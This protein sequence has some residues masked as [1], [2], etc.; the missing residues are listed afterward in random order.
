MLRIQFSIMAV[1]AVLTVA[2]TGA[3]VP[4]T[5]LVK[6]A[7]IPGRV[8]GLPGKLE[9]KLRAPRDHLSSSLEDELSKLERLRGGEGGLKVAFCAWESLHTV[10]VGGIAPHVSELAAGLQRRGNELHVF[11]RAMDEHGGHEIVDGVHLHKC[12]IY[13]DSDL[14]TECNNMCNS[15][16]H[17]VR[18]TEAHMN[19]EFDII[20]CHD[21]LAAKALVQMKQ[22][23]RRCILT[24]HST[25][26]GRNGNKH[27]DAEISGRIR[28]IEQEGCDYADRVICVSGRLCDEVKSF[29]C[30]HKLRM[31]YNGVQLHHFEGLIDA[32]YFKGQ[33]G[34]MPL[35]PMILFCGRMNVQKGPDILLN[36]VPGILGNR[37]DAVVVFVGEGPMKE[38]LEGRAHEMGIGH[39]VRFVGKK[40][41][42]E[43]RKFYK[44]CD[45]VVVPSR[46]E[47]FGIV[48]LEGWACAKPVVVTSTDGCGPGEF[49]R[50]E[51]DGFHVYPEPD[52]V[53]WG[54][55]QVMNDFERSRQ[56][57]L[58]GRQRCAD[59]FNWDKIA[60]HT[61]NVYYDV[62]GWH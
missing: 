38:Q 62:M 24:M 20:H 19:Y 36:A 51:D 15:F 47:P 14:P 52:S 27:S 43:L 30:D 25:E 5:T 59:E 21:W 8:Q 28:A 18:E 39:A 11:T 50:H 45:V 7:A 57:G 46:N 31:V 54:I 35:Q 55:N 6:R 2:V 56:M 40:A 4:T 32:A 13:T 16:V 1:L 42:D 48:V 37:G 26:Y 10:S 53:A 44:C 9:R 29:G 23:G 34:I 12:P 3:T 61:E 41:G 22:A 58:R 60:W 33:Y 49:V 17:F